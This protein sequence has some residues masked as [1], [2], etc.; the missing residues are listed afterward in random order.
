MPEP[1]AA[2]LKMKG[3]P[4]L[5]AGMG[6]ASPSAGAA[7]RDG[8]RCQEGAVGA[9]GRGLLHPSPLFPSACCTPSLKIFF[10][11]AKGCSEMAGNRGTQC[12]AG[13]D[14][15][16]GQKT[17]ATSECALGC[18]SRCR[19]HLGTSRWAQW[20]PDTAEPDK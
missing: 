13:S 15:Q 14:G 12:L 20:W 3:W 6:L 9:E 11:I 17:K 8:Q 19:A 2:S 16:G 4:A 5:L 7:F 18:P 1:T 10:P